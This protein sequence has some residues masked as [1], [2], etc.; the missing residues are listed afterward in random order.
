MQCLTPNPPDFFLNIN[1]FQLK[2]LHIHW[3]LNKRVESKTQLPSRPSEWPAVWT[4]PSLHLFFFFYK[5]LGMRR[6]H[7]NTSSITAQLFLASILNEECWSGLFNNW[8]VWTVQNIR[9][10]M[11]FKIAL[12]SV[13]SLVR[14]FIHKQKTGTS[15][16]AFVKTHTS[17]TNQ[18][19]ERARV[20]CILWCY[21]HA[22]CCCRMQ[23]SRPLRLYSIILVW[24]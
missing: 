1:G 14:G 22:Y 11:L 2:S 19:K 4:F 20:I 3:L 21:T 10:H 16:H 18:D 23:A 17:L 24:P 9:S 8:G 12:C 15:S 7:G 13:P 5:R 6:L